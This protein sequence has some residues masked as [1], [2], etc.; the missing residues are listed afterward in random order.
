[1]WKY[2]LIA[3]VAVVIFLFI[4][5]FNDDSSQSSSVTSVRSTEYGSTLSSSSSRYKSTSSSVSKT[6]DI[7]NYDSSV[8]DTE[9][10]RETQKAQKAI[11][12]LKYAAPKSL[13]LNLEGLEREVEQLITRANVLAGNIQPSQFKKGEHYL[14]YNQELWYKAQQAGVSFLHASNLVQEKLDQLH[15]IDFQD[16]SSSDRKLIKELQ[17]STGL[18]LLKKALIESMKMMFRKNVTF[19]DLIRHHCG[20]KGWAWAKKMDESGEEARS[21]YY[22]DRN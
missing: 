15:Q 6:I 11:N 19:K 17:S 20:D 2:I 9:F 13:N 21:G 10:Y 16:I 4:M 1:M 12:N 18:I 7:S 3:I 22:S 14:R 5:S 8:R